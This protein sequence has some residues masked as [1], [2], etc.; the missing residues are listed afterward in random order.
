[1]LNW[2]QTHRHGFGQVLTTIVSVTWLFFGF[3]TCAAAALS[4][5]DTPSNTGATINHVVSHNNHNSM[6]M[7]ENNGGPMLCCFF[8]TPDNF[9]SLATSPTKISSPS[10]DVAIITQDVDVIPTH[11]IITTQPLQKLPPGHCSIH[12]TIRFCTWLN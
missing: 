4:K 6:V 12:S 8:G 11:E 7:P 3:H 2:F 9:D 1:V 10:F 5:V